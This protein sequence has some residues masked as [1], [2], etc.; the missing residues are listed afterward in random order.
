MGIVY[1]Q[2]KPENFTIV[3]EGRV[4]LTDFGLCKKFQPH[5]MAFFVAMVSCR[6]LRDKEQVSVPLNSRNMSGWANTFSR[7][8]SEGLRNFVNL[9]G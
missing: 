3:T 9:T 4:V 7:N 1:R 8:G 2:L 5:E 6:E